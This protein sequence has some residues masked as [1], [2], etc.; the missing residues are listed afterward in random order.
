MSDADA[1]TLLAGHAPATM[2]GGKRVGQ[3]RKISEKSEPNNSKDAS[4]DSKDSSLEKSELE[5]NNEIATSQ[6][7]NS[8]VSGAP[9]RLEEA[10]PTEAVKHYHE[11][12]IPSHE[13][14][15]PTRSMRQI[16]QPNQDQFKK[17]TMK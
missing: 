2:V 12:I 17:K 8:L 7:A 9:V 13:N 1:K 16:N 15:M 4:K 14:K 5:E 3:A 6:T 11:K 10:Y